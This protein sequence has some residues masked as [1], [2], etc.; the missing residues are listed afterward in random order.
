MVY[1]VDSHAIVWFFEDSNELGRNA[2]N[3]LNSKDSRLIIP[4]IVIAEIFYLS[5]RR[6]I[7]STF[8]DIF[9]VIEQD[10]RCL[11]YPLDINIL[12]F[13]SPVLDIHD[14]ITSLA[15]KMLK[16]NKGLR[17]A[18]KLYSGINSNNHRLN[19]GYWIYKCKGQGVEGGVF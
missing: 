9:Q 5:Q 2:L 3:V 16:L 18:A 8:E 6:K 17:K 12:R 11:I 15:D 7:T 13:L 4:T 19:Y 10:D 1:V 14:E